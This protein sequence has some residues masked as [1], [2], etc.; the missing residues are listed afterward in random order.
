MAMWLFKPEPN[1]LQ[2]RDL[3]KDGSTTWDG[4]ANAVAQKHLRN[5]KKGDASSSITAATT[6][7]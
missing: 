2:F 6:G 7:P 5:V 1:C 4:V 3:Q